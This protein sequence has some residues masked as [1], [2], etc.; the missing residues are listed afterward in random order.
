LW[1]LPPKEAAEHPRADTRIDYQGRGDR[2]IVKFRTDELLKWF[3][4]AKAA[5]KALGEQIAT[6]YRR[7]IELLQAAPN[8]AELSKIP[9]LHFKAMAK[10]SPREGKYGV[11]LSGMMRMVVSI[12]GQTV[13]V[14]E[15]S[16]HYEE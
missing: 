13:V 5:R 14:E 1:A 9:Q 2:V 16:K 7:Q 11:R 4:S 10:G 12:E 8:T 6:A 15:V 3:E